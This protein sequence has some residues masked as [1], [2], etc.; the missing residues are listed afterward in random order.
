MTVLNATGGIV[1]NPTTNLFPFTDGIATGT[2]LGLTQPSGWLFV[3]L[4]LASASGPLGL[5]RQSWAS[6]A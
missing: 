5:V 3:N 4:N 6:W 2:A 1:S